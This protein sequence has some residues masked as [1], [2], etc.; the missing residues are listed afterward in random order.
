MNT[1]SKGTK[2]SSQGQVW[3]LVSIGNGRYGFQAEGDARVYTM[4]CAECH[5][6]LEAG[7]AVIVK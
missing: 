4:R 1:L 5:A 7:R 2:I 3:T 6:D